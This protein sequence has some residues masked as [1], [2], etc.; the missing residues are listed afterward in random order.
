MVLRFALVAALAAALIPARAAAAQSP[1]IDPL[2]PCYSAAQVGETQPVLISAHGFP[3]NDVIDVFV[4]NVFQT[5]PVG[6]A[7]PQADINGDLLNGSVPAPYIPLGVHRFTL[8]LADHAHPDI[9]VSATSKVAALTVEQ[10][11]KRASTRSRVRFSGRGFTSPGMVYAHYV[12]AGHSHK[13]VQISNT[14]GACGQFS[15][16][17]RQFPFKHTPKVGTWTIQFDQ[18]PR[19]DP[20]ASVLVR[21]TIKVNRTIKPKR[22]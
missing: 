17:L 18:V 8:R 20:K 1:S 16:K 2:A 3:P 14:R 21:L 6:S 9:T 4:D 11:P 13:T 12:Y 10:R 7:V 5:P 15:R 22:R 19:Y